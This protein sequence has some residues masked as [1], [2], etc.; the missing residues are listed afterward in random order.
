MRKIVGLA[1]L[2]I[3][4]LGISAQVPAPSTA[5][6]P[7]GFVLRAVDGGRFVDDLRLEDILLSEDG[8]AQNIDAVVLV[9]NNQVERK[10][11]LVPV[12]PET[13]RR[14][15]LVFYLTH[16][17]PQVEEALKRVLDRD[18]R[19]EDKLQ[20]RTLKGFYTL[21]GNALEVKSREALAK[22][23]AAVVRRDTEACTSV[24]DDML[25]SLKLMDDAFRG[26]RS[27]GLVEL[28][29]SN[30]IMSDAVDRF[31]PRY[32]QRLEELERLRAFDPILAGVAAE[33]NQTRV[34]QNS[35]ILF[36]EHAVR[37]ELSLDLIEAIYRVF[38]V[39]PKHRTELE[40]VTKIVQS[41]V[42]PDPPALQ[43]TFTNVNEQLNVID[44]PADTPPTVGA[45]RMNPVGEEFYA[46]F[47]QLARA[48]GGTVVSG[49]NPAEA[50]NKIGD[51]LGTYYLL[52]YQ[53]TNAAK[54]G[55]FRTVHVLLRN[56]AAELSYCRGY[57]AGR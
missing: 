16:F 37:P 6:L 55:A 12:I 42:L 2:G 41:K 40:A 30:S 35:V 27:G 3:L 23:L 19:P 22:E 29:G 26:V 31:I 43:K 14:I 28:R 56:R 5:P 36:Y 15:T 44:I 1:A 20:V 57:Y 49:L 51:G 39:N 24:Y 32:R 7:P 13:S 47:A 50:Y 53:P 17:T 54:D 38:Q 9:K 52:Y 25:T 10:E 45:A 48:T 46:A 33:E 11:G 34:G 8:R 4:S 18:I 21:G